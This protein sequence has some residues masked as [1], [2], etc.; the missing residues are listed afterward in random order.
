MALTEEE[1]EQVNSGINLFLRQPVKAASLMRKFLK[2]TN[3]MLI[4]YQRN[5][6]QKHREGQEGK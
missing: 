3:E 5:K 1:L 4:D 6:Q 2:E